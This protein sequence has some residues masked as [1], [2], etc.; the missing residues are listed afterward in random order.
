ML[1]YAFLIFSGVQPTSAADLLVRRSYQIQEIIFSQT[2]I[3]TLK[4]LAGI[5]S[6]VK[7]LR[8]VRFQFM[9]NK[10]P[11][12]LLQ[13]LTRL[14]SLKRVQIIDVPED[15]GF[16]KLGECPSLCHVEVNQYRLRPLEY[17]K[18]ITLANLRSLSLDCAYTDLPMDEFENG[19]ADSDK[20]QLVDLS[21]TCNSINDVHLTAI[22]TNCPNLKCLSIELRHQ[23]DSSKI[24]SNG[25]KSLFEICINLKTIVFITKR[26][27]EGLK[28]LLKEGQEMECFKISYENNNQVLIVKKN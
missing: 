4:K 6:S 25:I 10:L 24:T 22:A 3:S 12:D 14:E 13:K 7:N 21:F 19:L 27:H 28:R 23:M 8:S 11:K 17:K 16:H 20:S 5:I 18:I 9:R 1:T 26:S 15:S 2:S